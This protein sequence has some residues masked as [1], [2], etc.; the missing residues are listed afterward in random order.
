MDRAF[1]GTV[2]ITVH[3]KTRKIVSRD[4]KSTLFQNF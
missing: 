2:Q 4:L 3:C 1:E